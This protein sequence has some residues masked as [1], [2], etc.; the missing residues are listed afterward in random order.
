MQRLS[1]KQII[2]N[3]TGGLDI[4]DFLD[5]SLL[6]VKEQVLDSD[7]KKQEINSFIKGGG[8]QRKI[9][10]CN[11]LFAVQNQ[12]LDFLKFED[13]IIFKFLKQN[14]EINND[15]VHEEAMKN[16]IAGNVQI[17]RKMLLR[18]LF[19]NI[20]LGCRDSNEEKKLYTFVQSHSNVLFV[21]EKLK[22]LPSF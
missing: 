21:V 4:T 19:R 6:C 16:M 2:K 8:C 14:K 12:T 10:D 15:E 17:Q 9:N 7:M 3:Y 11:A 22:I 13:A 1:T 5:S 18:C 20:R